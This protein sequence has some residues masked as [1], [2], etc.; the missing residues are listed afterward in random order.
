MATDQPTLIALVDRLRG[1]PREGATF[2][3]KSNLSDPAE[4]GRYLSALANAA[5]LERQDR[6]WLVWG[7]DDT[8]HKVAG[9]KFD[10]HSA[11]G[12]GNQSLTMW[13][14]QRTQPRPDFT[15]YEVQHPHG[16]VVVL[17]IQAPRAAPL[18]FDGVRYIRVDSH[19]TKLS[20]HPDNLTGLAILSATPRW[21]TLTQ[22]RWMQRAF[23]S[24]STC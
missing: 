2:E 16:R 6:A 9:T 4:I 20:E 13:L 22:L 11:K 14:T 23:V 8:T 1:Q 21:M 17:A 15:F 3:F 12:D 5:V 10:P 18:A 24:S 19:K 7:V